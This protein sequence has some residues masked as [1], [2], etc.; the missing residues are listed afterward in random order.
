MLH[1]QYIKKTILVKQ[2][3]PTKGQIQMGE[4]ILVLILFL[5]LLVFGVVVYAKFQSL[6][7]KKETS[8][9][10]DLLGE[11]IARKIRLLPELQCTLD[12]VVQFDCYDIMKLKA[13]VTTATDSS[14]K[15]Y[16]DAVVFK[17]AHVQITSI[18]PLEETFSLYGFQDSTTTAAIPY[19]AP[20][21]LYDP[22]HETTGFGYITVE[23]Y[24]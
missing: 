6:S 22:F 7:M 17:G 21:L 8:E 14:Y 12:G 2:R 23:V 18:F 16:Y 5:F 13:F 4:S 10:Q 11:T 20:V 1:K 24:R 3:S 9:R 15:L 19:R